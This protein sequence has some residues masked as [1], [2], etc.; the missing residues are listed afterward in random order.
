[1]VMLLWVIAA[2]VPGGFRI[3]AV[4]YGMMLSVDIVAISIVAIGIVAIVMQERAV[5]SDTATRPSAPSPSPTLP[6]PSPPTQFGIGL[7]EIKPSPLPP[8]N[9]H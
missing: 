1:V 5:N 3:R 7:P 9:P 6:P 8:R 4:V 2:A